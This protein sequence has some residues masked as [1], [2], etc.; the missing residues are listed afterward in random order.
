MHFFF[1]H[2]D[3]Q[4]VSLIILVQTPWLTRTVFKYFFP[5]VVGGLDIHKKMVVDVWA[6]KHP[7]CHL[8][9]ALSF[10][11]L[12][13]CSTS[14]KCSLST[15]VFTLWSYFIATPSLVKP[16]CKCFWTLILTITWCSTLLTEEQL[17][18]SLSGQGK[19]GWLVHFFFSY[20]FLNYIYFGSLFLSKCILS[21]LRRRKYC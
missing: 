9:H 21:F 3:V 2:N 7:P 18:A 16:T 17:R 5:Q 10:P 8:Q 12:M 19:T 11:S 14:S 4:P 6:F 20:F 1:K 15:E 13:I